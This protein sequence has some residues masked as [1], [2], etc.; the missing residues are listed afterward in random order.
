MSTIFN[1][2]YSAYY[3]GEQD[4]KRYSSNRPDKKS[5][6]AQHGAKKG[7]ASQYGKRDVVEFSRDGMEAL[8]ESGRTSGKTD[9]AKKSGVSFGEEGLSQRAQELLKKLRETYG[10]MDFFV[11]DPNKVNNLK[12]IF[13][14]STKEFAVIISGEELEKMASDEEYAAKCMEK[15]ENAVSMAERIHQELAA[16]EGA[17]GMKLN[18][19]VISLNQDGTTSFFAEL[20]RSGE[21]QR[22][23][24]EEAREERHA[25]KKEQEKRAEREKREERIRI[26]AGSI[27]ELLEEIKKRSLHT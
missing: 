9:S 7:A 24:I 2:D 3:K 18:K 19:L 8:R 10:N 27:E 14:R 15:I 5:G 25:E 22:E 17:N 26:R 11:G 6:S 23:R 21:K 12:D 4:Y 1:Q 20:E 16:G 13:S